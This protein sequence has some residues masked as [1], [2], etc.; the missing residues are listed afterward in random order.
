MSIS[1]V[2]SALKYLA[3]WLLIWTA[4]AG[5]AELVLRLHGEQPS[6]D[7]G[8]LYEQ[9]GTGYKLRPS[10]DTGA[11]WSTGA[12][13]VHTDALGLRCDLA[14]RMGTRQYDKV[15]W[16]FLGDSQ[17]FGNG[18]SYEDTIVG[19]VAVRAAESGQVVRNACIGGQK[20]LNQ[21]ELATLLRQRDGL[22][23]SNYV[24]LFTPVAVATCGSFTT[25]TVGP[26]G[27]L[28]GQATTR[29]D[30]A[31]TW[32]KTHSAAYGRVRDAIR[33]T[34]FG[35]QPDEETP[36][37]FG[38]YRTGETEEGSNRLCAEV[39]QRLKTFASKGNA[40]VQLVYMPLTLEM[41]FD[42]IQSGANKRGMAVDV[43]A[44]FRVLSAAAKETGLP[45]HDLRPVLRALHAT[46][47][48][49]SLFPDFHY[50]PAVSRASGL[51][52]W[53]HLMS[54]VKKSVDAETGLES[55]E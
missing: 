32:I 55:G 6:E 25:A 29:G 17:G 36:F 22:R 24:Y 49:L 12:F 38:L 14:R 8:G 16:L 1:S 27:R 46:G 37:V 40:S 48:P 21:L 28:Y 3:T 10:V 45:L 50:T 9:F 51:S 52:I 47:Q 5:A 34:G 39:L 44:P 23:V 35:V 11:T 19:T 42:A 18:V 2:R 4:S 31:R 26:D 30:I 33:S 53:E 20:P 43:N 41:N 13:S 15:D 7:L 54:S